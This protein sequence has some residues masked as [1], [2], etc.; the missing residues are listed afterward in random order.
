MV[1]GAAGPA[2]GSGPGLVGA[3]PVRRAEGGEREVGLEGVVGGLGLQ[4]HVVDLA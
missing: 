1:P 2:V 4:V 3:D